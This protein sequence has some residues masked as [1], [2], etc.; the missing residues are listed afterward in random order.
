M[1]NNQTSRVL[2]TF[3]VTMILCFAS[4][5]DSF[6]FPDFAVHPRNVE[7]RLQWVTLRDTFRIDNSGDEDLEWSLEIDAE[8]DDW[9]SVNLNEGVVRP[10]QRQRFVLEQ[11]GRGVD[12]DHVYAFMNFTS[13]DP[14]REEYTVPVVGHTVEYPRIEVGWQDGW[15]AWWGID[16]NRVFDEILW[17][18]EYSFRIYIRN[19][20]GGAALFVDDLP[21]NNGYFELD[22]T[23][24]NVA[25]D[26]L[27]W[28]T[29]TF[30]ADQV[31]YHTAIITSESNAWDP[32]ELNFRI[33]GEVAAVFRRDVE[34]PNL[35]VDEDCN[36]FYIADLDS[37]FISSQRGVVYEVPVA[38]GLVPRI[39]RNGEF[40]LRPRRNWNGISDVIITASI[41]DTT[42]ADTFSV[43]VN[44]QPD[45][46]GQ[47]GLLLPENG[48]TIH[49]TES[50]SLFIWQ[51]SH[52]P[53]G[54]SV[55]YSFSIRTG[56]FPVR[57]DDL[58]DTSISTAIL[59]DILSMEIGGEFTWTVKVSDGEYEVDAISEFTNILA[60]ASINNSEN[61]PQSHSLARVF[62]NPFNNSLNIQVNL[63]KR[64]QLRLSV[65]D[66]KGRLI[67]VLND[68]FARRG[69]NTF[70]WVPMDA[71]SGKYLI[72]VEMKGCRNIYPVVLSR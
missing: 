18:E 72:Q 52:D 46:P 42:I 69:E 32:R 37:V 2:L 43:T 55:F 33:V 9:I 4:V 47:F 16:M 50:D 17:G 22:P 40:F 21:C 68:G 64:E 12:E 29:V 38:P 62:P 31:G 28:I 39:E 3:A 70:I 7:H 48:A 71:A 53:D 56:G 23:E 24:F 67:A 10:G 30:T 8:V 14:T 59:S 36:E 20:W 65:Y 54:D 11:R 58:A 35:N 15:G 5:T 66:L 57:W 13:N 27:Q 25:H 63:E 34:L 49:P 45:P 6:A 19:R 44:P 1:I 60:P 41:E 26:A 51:K 61:T